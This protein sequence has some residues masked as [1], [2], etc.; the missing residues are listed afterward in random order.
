MADNDDDDIFTVV[1]IDDGAF[2]RYSSRIHVHL[3]CIWFDAVI[4]TTLKGLPS[5]PTLIALLS[6]IYGRCAS[7]HYYILAC[8][9]LPHGTSN[10]RSFGWDAQRPPRPSGNGR[11]PKKLT[12][13]IDPADSK[14]CS[15]SLA[16]TEGT[17]IKGS[18]LLRRDK[19]NA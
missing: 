7:E 4:L 14:Y 8:H 12:I 5:S 19:E 11:A 17:L 13:S 15:F 6:P 9:N 10:Y 16:R 1:V 2:T 18:E 3:W